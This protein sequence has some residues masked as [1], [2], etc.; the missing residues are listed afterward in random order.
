MFASN[1][2]GR[3]SDCGKLIDE[4]KQ[5]Y[6]GNDGTEIGQYGGN[7]PWDIRILSPQITKCNVAAKTTADGKLSVDIEV[8]AAE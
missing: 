7:L 3:L 2:N 1:P 5:K 6:V 4:A 8:K